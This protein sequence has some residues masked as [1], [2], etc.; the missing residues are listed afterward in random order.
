[1]SAATI[2]AILQLASALAPPAIELANKLITAAEK[3]EITLEDIEA[4]RAKLAPM[5]AV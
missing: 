4:L 1:M 2:L 5:S 3:G